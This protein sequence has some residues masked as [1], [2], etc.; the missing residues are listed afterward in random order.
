MNPILQFGTSRFL[1]AHADLFVS[2]ALQSGNALGHI[3]IVQTTGSAESARRI[4]AFTQPGGYPVIVRGRANGQVIDAEQKVTSVTEALQASRDWPAIRAG[5]A[6]NVKV[7]LSN[8]GDRGYQLSTEDHAGLVDSDT[9]PVSFP[10]KLLV[11]LYARFKAG[12]APITL[13]PCELV[14]SNGDVLR[15]LVV[16]IARQWGLDDAFITYLTTQCVWVNSLVDRIVSQPLEPVGAV[17]EPYAL[18]AIEAQPG[19]TLP[20]THPQVVVTDNLVQFEQLKLW[21]LNLGH[22]YLAERWLQDGRAQDETV[23]QAMSDPV[24]LAELEALWEEEVIPV[25]AAL[26]LEA[27]ARQYLI[28]VRERFSNPFLAHR[29][30]DIAQ[31]HEEKKRRRFLPVVEMAQEKQLTIAQTRLRSALQLAVVGE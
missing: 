6:S 15:G 21:L 9:P 5:V 29:V 27:D 31:N 25:F 14:V 10:A 22:S 26:N 20:C 2:E 4:A 8:T 30:A 7:I 19:M 28:E 17:A 16:D 11:L 24:L 18:W 3:T 1:Q 23:L 12:A 13:F